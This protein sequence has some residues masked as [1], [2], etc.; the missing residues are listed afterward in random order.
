MNPWLQI[1]CLIIYTVLLYWYAYK[2][3]WGACYWKYEEVIELFEGDDGEEE[4]KQ[5]D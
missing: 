1:L 5:Q 2:H 4:G 3:G